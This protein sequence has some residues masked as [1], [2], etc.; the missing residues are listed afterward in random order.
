MSDPWLTEEELAEHQ[1]AVDN[2]PLTKKAEEAKSAHEGDVEDARKQR[3]ENEK[4]V[5]DGELVREYANG[6]V[7]GYRDAD[8]VDE[9][10]AES[11]KPKEQAVN[12]GAAPEEPVV[13]QGSAD[14]PDPKA[15]SDPKAD[16]KKN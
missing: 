1:K 10:V 13:V 11:L 5:E 14:D 7:V 12:A 6:A 15:D 8:A 4:K 16:K 2:H 3:E 9:P